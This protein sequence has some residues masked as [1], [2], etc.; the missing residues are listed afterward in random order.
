MVVRPGESMHYT[1]GADAGRPAILLVPSLINR[2]Y[3]WDLRHGDSFVER[4]LAAGY[5]VLCLDWVCLTRAR[6]EHLVDLC[7]RLHDGRGRRGDA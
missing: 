1:A 2:A 5:D 6:P 4:L 3:I 7:R